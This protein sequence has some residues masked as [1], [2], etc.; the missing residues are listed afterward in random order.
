MPTGATIPLRPFPGQWLHGECAS[1]HF[2]SN[3]WGVVAQG[4][5]GVGRYDQETGLP[6]APDGLQHMFRVILHYV[7]DMV[8]AHRDWNE[9]LGELDPHLVQYFVTFY[10]L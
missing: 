6:N 10:E 2:I 8:K 1:Y 3:R 4:C 9:Y 5:L 7:R